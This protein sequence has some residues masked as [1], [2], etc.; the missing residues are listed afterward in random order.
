MPQWLETFAI[1]SLLIGSLCSLVIVVDLLSGHK[2]HMWIMD[3]VWPITALY[4]GLLGLYAYFTIG[5][6]SSTRR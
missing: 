3:M 1:I 6:L 4:S 5:R 2:Q